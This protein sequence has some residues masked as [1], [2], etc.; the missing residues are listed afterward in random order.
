MKGYDIMKV[1]IVIDNTEDFS[2]ETVGIYST[3]E[4]AIGSAIRYAESI[5]LFEDAVEEGDYNTIEAAKKDFKKYLYDS[6]NSSI[7]IEE[8]EIDKE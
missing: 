7:V 5:G 4:K 3:K 1:Y 2:S 6:Y 8:Y